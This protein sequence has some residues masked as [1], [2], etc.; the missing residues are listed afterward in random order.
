[1]HRQVSVNDGVQA[2]PCFMDEADR[3][4]IAAAHLAHAARRFARHDPAA[5]FYLMEMARA[6]RI[7]ALH[8]KAHAPL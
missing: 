6:L 5:Q 4:E 1:M 7:E 3:D 2:L 8:R